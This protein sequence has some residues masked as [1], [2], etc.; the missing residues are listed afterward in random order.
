MEEASSASDASPAGEAPDQDDTSS[1]PVELAGGAG[2]SIL[3]CPISL[4]PL[5]TATDAERDAMEAARLNG[6]LSHYSGEPVRDAIQVAVVSSDGAHGY[7]QTEGIYRLL[8]ESGFAVPGS[9]A[10]ATSAAPVALQSDKRKIKRFYDDVGWV[11]DEEGVFGDT[12]IFV[13]RRRVAEE[14]TTR[15]HL[16]VNDHIPDGGRY[17]LDAGCGAIPH[18]EYLTYS[19]GFERRI[20][21]DLSFRGLQEARRKLGD[22]GIYIEGDI[23]ALPLADNVFDAGL[24][25]HTVY[26]VPAAEQG[27]V[28]TELSRVLKPKAPGIVVYAF[29]GQT[30]MLKLPQLAYR[31]LLRLR[32]ALRRSGETHDTDSNADGTFYFHSHP[33]EWFTRQEGLRITEIRSWRSLNNRLLSSLFH[34]R[35]LGRWLLRGV[36]YLEGRFPRFFGRMGEY[37]LII[38]RG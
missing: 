35:L 1:E 28:L 30:P 26:H 25:L 13:D 31:A 7:L 6:D 27:S 5:R 37:P 19:E 22:R 8:P 18:P 17:I 36:F 16:R 32:N 4:L 23:T 29:D 15:C 12:E 20:C 3:R 2:G 11:G 10:D 21:V 34:G 33:Y 9:A 14:Y 24:A 38:L